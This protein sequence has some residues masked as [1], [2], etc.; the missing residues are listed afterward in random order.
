[1]SGIKNNY[2]QLYLEIRDTYTMKRCS[3]VKAKGWKGNPKDRSI[4][5][6]HVEQ[7]REGKGR[8]TIVRL[9]TSTV[10]DKHSKNKPSF[11]YSP[12]QISFCSIL[13]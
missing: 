6:E 2:S 10:T 11:T 12:L 4:E 1:M 3:Q 9:E 5:G 13:C 8:L 7:C